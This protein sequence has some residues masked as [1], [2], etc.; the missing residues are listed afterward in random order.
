MMDFEA[1]RAEVE[2][3]LISLREARGR[4]I[5]AGEKFDPH[6]IEDAERELAGLDD[7]ERQQTRLD[8]EAADAEAA[9]HRGALIVAVKQVETERLAALAD[10]E[11][12]TRTLASALARLDKAFAEERCFM[13][14]GRRRCTARSSSPRHF[15][16]GSVRC[17]GATAAGT[18][19]TGSHGA[20]P[21]PSAPLSP[22]ASHSIYPYFRSF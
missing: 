9:K 15:A 2:E 11:M 5:V 16:T 20:N 17:W 14:S 3:R 19:G 12:A 6:A 13:R 22:G 4:A 8:R 18:N 7:A 10:A 1:A 21:R